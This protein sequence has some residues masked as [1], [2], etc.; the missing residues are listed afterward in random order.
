MSLKCSNPEEFWCPLDK[1]EENK[2][3]DKIFIKN[4][5]P[6]KWINNFQNLLYKESQIQQ[7]GVDTESVALKGPALNH[8]ID[9]KELSQECKERIETRQGIWNR[10][11]YNK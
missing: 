3:N 4:I 5:H 2:S 11:S 10:S 8:S 1:L 6:L 9:E 7:T